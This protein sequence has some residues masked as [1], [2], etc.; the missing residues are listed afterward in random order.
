MH[1]RG[2]FDIS[3]LIIH[4]LAEDNRKIPTSRS[5]FFGALQKLKPLIYS[6]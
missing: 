5:Q 6:S 3:I 1:F 4:L 2:T